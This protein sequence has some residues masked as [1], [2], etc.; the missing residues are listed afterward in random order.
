MIA[1][2]LNMHN[3]IIKE[4]S[5]TVD[6]CVVTKDLGLTEE[7]DPDFH[8]LIQYLI[9]DKPP[10]D[11]IQVKSGRLVSIFTIVSKIHTYVVYFADQRNNHHKSCTIPDL[12]W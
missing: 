11:P 5:F 9:H 6:A 12:A 3:L 2:D 4:S 10:I 1:A 7:E 8:D